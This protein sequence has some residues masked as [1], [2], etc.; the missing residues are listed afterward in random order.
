MRFFVCLS[1]VLVSL[2][3]SV[4]HAAGQE[5]IYIPMLNKHRFINNRIVTPPFIKS[6]FQIN[7]GLGESQQVNLPG[8]EIADTVLSLEGGNLIYANLNT[9][10]NV[11][12]NNSVAY[13]FNIGFSARIGSEPI[14][15]YTNGLNTITGIKNAWKIRLFSNDKHYLSTM[16]GISV[17]DANV[18]NISSF[19][20]D[21]I[22]NEPVRNISEDINV[23]RGFAGVYYATAFGSLLGLNAMAQYV[24]GDSFEAGKST[25]Q[26]MASLALDLNLYPKTNIPLGLS[27][28]YAYVALPDFTT[29]ETETTFIANAKLAY[30]GNESFLISLDGSTFKAPYLLGRVTEATDIETTVFNYSL[31]V[32]IY[33]N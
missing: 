28:A 13:Y 27:M 2:L 3:I 30:T 16:I 18:V 1:F 29:V 31:N 7:M 8:I 20:R 11:T 22:N 21:L 24:Y 4:Q 6:S 12:L 26:A 10:L 19:I 14:S 32:I 9:E 15:L 33:F 23:L 5:K 25:S 17:Y